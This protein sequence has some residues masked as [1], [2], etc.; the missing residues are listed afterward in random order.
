M[1]LRLQSTAFETG[2]TIPKRYTC[3]GDNVSPALSGTGVPAE[4]NCLV[5]ACVD[6]VAPGGTFHHWAV[7]NIPADWNGLDDGFSA[8]GRGGRC[9]DGVND[10]RKVGYGGPCP[11]RGDKPHGYRFRLAALDALLP[12]AERPMS[13]HEILRQAKPHEIAVAEIIGYYGR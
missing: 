4:A 7:Y 1:S 3:D 10:F 12:E 11:P 5:L 6:P 13:C 2:A 9:P 8:K